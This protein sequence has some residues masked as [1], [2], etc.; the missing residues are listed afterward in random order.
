MLG[1]GG[2]DL[3]L[4]CLYPLC[5]ESR[6]DQLKSFVDKFFHNFAIFLAKLFARWHA[7]QPKKAD[8]FR[9][10]VRVTHETT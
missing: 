6:N 7:T 2:S 8:K 9:R 1:R 10:V 4:I 3:G 5:S